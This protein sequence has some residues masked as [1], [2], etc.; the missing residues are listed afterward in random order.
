MKKLSLF[1]LSLLFIVPQVNADNFSDVYNQHLND[2]AIEYLENEKII[3]GYEDGTYKPDNRINRAEFTKIVIEALY[4]DSE[5]NACTTSNFPD[6]PVG[7]WFA[8]YVCKAVQEGV[9]GG[10]PDGTFNPAGF[11]NF[12]EASKIVA[13][14][15]G[16]TGS[17]AGTN[18]EW[19]APYVK[20]LEAKSAIPSTVGFF[21]EQITRGE[22]AEVIWRL[23]ADKTDEISATYEE[24]TD[25][26]PSIASCEALEEKLTAYQYRPYYRT[27]SLPE[28]EISFAA[29]Q[30]DGA[31]VRSAVQKSISAEDFSQ[32]NIQVEGVDEADIIKNDGEFIYLIKG[33][34]VRI[35]KAYPGTKMKE[36]AVIDFD[37]DGFFPSQM[38]VTD[39]RLVAIG[40]APHY[41]YDGPV[42]AFTTPPYYQGSQSKVFVYDISDR[43]NPK[44]IRE[45]T[46]DG[47]Y[48]TSRRIG[49]YVYLVLN[50]QPNVWDYN[51]IKTGKDFL[52]EFKDGDKKAEDMVGCTGVRYF[53]GYRI[54]QYLITASIDIS[55]SDT[56]IERN[57]FLGSSDN[58][59][60]SSTDLYVAGTMRSYDYF[61]DWDWARDRAKTNIFR[62]ALDKGN[63]DFKARGTVPGTILNQFSMDEYDEYFRIATTTGNLWSDVNPSSNNVF[64]F[65]KDMEQ[66]GKL[67]DIAPGEKIYS[68]R[69]L[70]KRLYMVT[71]RQ[72]DPL[73]VFDLGDPR[74]PVILGKLK[75]P[76]FSEY[77]HPFDENNILGFGKETV[78]GKDFTLIDGMK[79]AL[80]DVSDVKNPK[81]KFVEVIGD[82]GT[83]SELLYNH[84]AL[85][86]DKEKELLA[87]PIQI[88]EEDPDLGYS[89][90]TF[91]GAIVYNINAED[92]FEERGRIS[93]YTDEDILSFGD[94][95]P[96]DNE[97]T[98][99]RILYIGEYLYTVAQ[100][101]IKANLLKNLKDIDFVELAD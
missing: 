83:S 91:S 55:G 15:E 39:D 17:S 19:F 13:S 48:K 68:T 89:T 20:G 97:K 26:F 62:F 52:P 74:R 27:I 34:E 6:V 63:I 77:L 86:F 1:L 53:P 84:K 42:S 65:N 50:A 25:P 78:E 24:I 56:G 8:K 100:G 36:V 93:H 40:G 82:R 80:F 64:V 29:E 47:D 9:I 71:F 76:G 33:D 16:V 88:Q 35:V 57:V 66:V 28:G 37:S 51:G 2:E 73:F 99:Q 10:Y 38:Y 54:P 30:T 60:S 75:I 45:V 70:G 21:D 18:N 7:E 44:Q 58:I 22:M 11:I 98:I 4:S 81:Q 32:T 49:D 31:T 14:A 90:T 43:S 85:L 72:V 87:F 95:W 59:Y 23:E 61:T 41:Y 3:E 12:A 96:Y 92:G 69:F 46:F 79:I 67:T 5:I 101:G 94:Y